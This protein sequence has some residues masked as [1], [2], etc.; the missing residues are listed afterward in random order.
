MKQA[1]YIAIGVIAASAIFLIA[2]FVKGDGEAV[3]TVNGKAIEKDALYEELVKTSGPDTLN[4]MITDEILDQEAEKADINVTEEELDKE[5]AVYEKSYGGKDALAAA[6]ESSGMTM[7]DLTA[8]MESYVK[9]EKLLGPDIE[10]TDGEIESYFE[11]NKESL[12]QPAQVE[13]SHILTATKEE[14]DEVKEKLAAG[15]DFAELAKEYSTDTATAQNGGELGFFGTGEMAA[16]FEEAAFAMKV[17]DISDPV[18]TDFGF[19]I[20]QVTDKKEAAEA[21]LEDSKDQIKELLFDQK[22]NAAYTTWIAEKQES[23]EI[24][25]TL[26]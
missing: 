17:D 18:E 8:E 24:E 4:A 15:G 23:Y 26:N 13:A 25:N 9:V 21:T 19:H 14:A 16:E 22:L 12:A 10:V 6:V 7:E 5:M 2:G 1:V 11:E 20:I 3:A